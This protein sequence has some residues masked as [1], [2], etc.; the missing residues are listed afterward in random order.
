[1]LVSSSRSFFNFVLVYKLL[2]LIFSSQFPYL[3]S[4]VVRLS[5]V[6]Q[7][8]QQM[9]ITWMADCCAHPSVSDSE[10]VGGAP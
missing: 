7:L 8:D 6:P 10:G 9:R 1:M 4:E 5:V 2:P 3:Y